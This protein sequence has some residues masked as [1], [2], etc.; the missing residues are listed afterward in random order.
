MD[1]EKEKIVDNQEHHG[2]LA[3]PKL[4]GGIPLDFDG[5]S[6]SPGG[7]VGV[8]GVSGQR[9]KVRVKDDNIHILSLGDYQAS[10][11]AEIKTGKDGKDYLSFAIFTREPETNE[12]NP[13]FYAGRLADSAIDY[14]GKK[15]EIA[16]ILIEWHPGSDNYEKYF[17]LK[18][19]LL[20][21]GSEEQAKQ[22][23]ALGTW[24]GSRIAQ[25]HGFI[26]VEIEEQEEK[27]ERDQRLG[28]GEKPGIILRGKFYK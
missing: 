21:E 24:E 10:F 23:A 26:R 6:K 2:D 15:H 19:Q 9:I 14:F 17:Q 12:R 4:V 27:I 11:N 5:I 28:E 16:G 7:E 18:K 8:E 1:G 3:K 20:A 13:D 25:P 22:K